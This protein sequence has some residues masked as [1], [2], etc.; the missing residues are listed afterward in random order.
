MT[1]RTIVFIFSFALWGLISY[2]SF[3]IVI[4]EYKYKAEIQRKIESGVCVFID[5]YGRCWSA[6]EYQNYLEEEV[7]IMKDIP[8]ELLGEDN[9]DEEFN[10]QFK[11]R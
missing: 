8:E 9:K 6:G 4:E 3:Q 1:A 11:L 7:D 2:L 5:Q 10:K